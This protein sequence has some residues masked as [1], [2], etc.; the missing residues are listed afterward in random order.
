[1]VRVTFVDGS[2]LARAQH[3]VDEV[4]PDGVFVE[5]LEGML[6]VNPP[7]SLGH[8]LL[9]DRVGRELERLAP[10]GLTVNWAGMGVYEHNSAQAEYQVPDV[11]VFRSP[12][13]GAARL[14]GTDVEAVVE[15]ISPA[16]RRQ[17][18]Y[19][20]AVAARAAR[21]RISWALVIDPDARSMS[22]FRNGDRSPVGADWVASPDATVLFG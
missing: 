2:L 5:V 19:A 17:G 13:P 6:V 10:P 12:G 20:A 4:L 9:T 18:D 1:M 16:N 22:W 15:V 7:P 3:A 11:V 21:Y 8:G 14:L